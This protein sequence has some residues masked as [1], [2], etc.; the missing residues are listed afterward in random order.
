MSLFDKIIE[1]I[2][3]SMKKDDIF[4]EIKILCD[5]IQNEETLLDK[6][7]LENIGLS[8]PNKLLIFQIKDNNKKFSKY[9][10][11]ERD[12]QTNTNGIEK[13]YLINLYEI[14]TIILII[15]NAIV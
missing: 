12:I 3:Q 4:E 8:D 15:F 10:V 9:L 6:D 13:S 7:K 5:K 14:L 11:L 2:K 1:E